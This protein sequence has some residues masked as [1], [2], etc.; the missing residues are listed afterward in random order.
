M[1]PK[2]SLSLH[3]ATQGAYDGRDHYTDAQARMGRALTISDGGRGCTTKPGSVPLILKWASMIA[4][5]SSSSRSGANVQATACLSA[6]L[7][8]DYHG[9]RLWPQEHALATGHLLACAACRAAASERG[10]PLPVEVAQAEPI[11]THGDNN[12]LRDPPKVPER[13]GPY[14]ILRLIGRGGMGA[15]YEAR[16]TKLDR[17]VALKILPSPLTVDREYRERFAREARVIARL[18]HP[19]VVRATDAGEIDGYPFLALDLLDGMDV[20]RLVRSLGPPPAA[21]AAEIVRQ[22]ASGLVHLHAKGIIHRDVKPSNLMLTADGLVK[23]LDLGLALTTEAAGRTDGRLTGITFL[24]THDYMSP[25]QWVDPTAVDA[26]ADIYGLG[27]VLFQ[28]LAGRSP[29]GSPRMS[30]QAKMKAHLEQPVPALPESGG[31][32][33]G[34]AGLLERMLSKEPHQRPTA[35]EVVAELEF[36]RDPPHLTRLLERCRLAP[37]CGFSDGEPTHED[38]V[39]R[40]PSPSDFQSVPPTAIV[41]VGPAPQGTPTAWFLIGLL[42]TAAITVAGWAVSRLLGFGL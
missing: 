35:A 23:I 16:H 3:G 24:G 1:Y 6:E 40:S 36:P 4:D 30:A 14:R 33:P 42:T 32:P 2:T 13:I 5:V 41:P 38:P 37:A 7:I 19:N 39:L 15:V 8:D 34:L 28:M 17:V 9:G 26:K 29:F 11:T 20:A 31:F 25:E 10:Y 18:D 27:C 21:D 22:A 12:T